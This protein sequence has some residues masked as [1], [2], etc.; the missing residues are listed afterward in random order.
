[1]A[2]KYSIKLQ[3]QHFETMDRKALFDLFTAILTDL[4][5]VQ[6]DLAEIKT[7]YNATLAKLDADAGV[8]DTNYAATNP[9]GTQS[10]ASLNLIS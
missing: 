6:T 4:T 9:I 7:D 10:S 2:D 1:M 8:T 5:N 3:M